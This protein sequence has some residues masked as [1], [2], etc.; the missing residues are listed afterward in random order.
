MEIVRYFYMGH[1]QIYS[2]FVTYKFK[3][4][5]VFTLQNLY[6]VK[7]IHP[8]Y[9]SKVTL[10]ETRISQQT[11]E[12]YNVHRYIMSA[13]LGHSKWKYLPRYF[14][15]PSVKSCLFCAMQCWIVELDKQVPIYIHSQKSQFVLQQNYLFTL[16]LVY[17]KCIPNV[18]FVAT[19]CPRCCCTE[20]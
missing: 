19:F 16:S 9:K 6:L 11:C 17:Q 7:F 12:K 15:I 4:G 10:R 18:A 14:Y 5:D 8:M 13:N 1:L 20:L 2:I 3:K